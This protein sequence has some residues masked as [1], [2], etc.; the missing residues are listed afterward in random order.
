[1]LSQSKNLRRFFRR[2]IRKYKDC[3]ERSRRR[4][5]YYAIFCDKDGHSFFECTLGGAMDR[6][7]EENHTVPGMPAGHF[8]Y[9]N[10]KYGKNG[11]VLLLKR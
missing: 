10:S 8:F 1:M 11:L 6:T 5:E 2:W 9:L 7:Q 4:K 3:E